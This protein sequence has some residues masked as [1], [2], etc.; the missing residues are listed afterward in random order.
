MKEQNA[1]TSEEP[2][3]KKEEDKATNNK[4]KAKTSS[5]S[6]KTNQSG[7]TNQNTNS[8]D[9]LMHLLTG[10]GALGGNYL[11]FIKPL[12]EKF[13]AMNQAIIYHEKVIKE[14]QEQIDVLHHKIKK[15][16]KKEEDIKENNED[17]LFATK[18]ND[19]TNPSSMNGARRT[20]RF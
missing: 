20:A 17:E 11:L 5:Q 18:R 15:A 2:S 1:K 16:K 6:E 8:P 9:W 3:H 12:Q 4:Q 14:M 13:E 7:Q 10:A 19:K